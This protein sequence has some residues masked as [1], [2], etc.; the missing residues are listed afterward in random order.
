[1]FGLFFSIPLGIL[2][3]DDV[4]DYS[5]CK[6]V[7]LGAEMIKKGYEKMCS[8]GVLKDQHKYLLMKCLTYAM[9]ILIKFHPEWIKFIIT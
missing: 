3:L 8:N 7:E 4:Q 2:M 9:D 5:K 6:I 1:M